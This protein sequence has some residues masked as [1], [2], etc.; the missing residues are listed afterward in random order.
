MVFQHIGKVHPTDDIAVRD[1]HIIRRGTAQIAQHPGK[2]FQ[3]AAAEAGAAG[4]GIGREKGD[5]APL[6]GKIPLL[7]GADMLHQGMII[8][9]HHN[10][11]GIHPGVGHAGKDEVHQAVAAG[12]RN[13]AHGTLRGQPAQRAVMRVGKD[14]PCHLV[15]CHFTAPPQC[16]VPPWSGP[17]Q[18]RRRPP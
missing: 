11:D 14:Y 6:A 8:V 5:A 12:K 18:R 17:A 7:A 2:G 10:G 1:R 16:P 15:V 4:G 13:R 3:R 9:L